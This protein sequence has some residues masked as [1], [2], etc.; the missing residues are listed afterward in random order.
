MS[1]CLAVSEKSDE[2]SR[3]E[4]LLIHTRSQKHREIYKHTH[5]HTHTN[6]RAN[7]TT[8]RDKN[9]VTFTDYFLAGKKHAFRS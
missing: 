4:L 9:D 3:N 8:K 6:A 2:D 5:T 7:N 1:L